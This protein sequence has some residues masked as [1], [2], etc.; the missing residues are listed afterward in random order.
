MKKGIVA[1]LGGNKK[2]TMKVK[3]LIDFFTVDYPCDKWLRTHVQ[4]FSRRFNPAAKC[5][6]QHD[7]SYDL[8]FVVKDIKVVDGV[9]HIEL[10]EELGVG[11]SN[12]SIDM[13][14][15]AGSLLAS[16]EECIMFYVDENGKRHNYEIAGYCIYGQ[17]NGIELEEK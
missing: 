6:I 8:M 9:A 13:H 11:D 15:V 12:D 17:N 5:Y 16:C 7:L 2:K 14:F 3:Q 10:E 4:R 1:G